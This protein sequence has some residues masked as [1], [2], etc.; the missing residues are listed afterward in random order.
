MRRLLRTHG[1]PLADV[2]AVQVWTSAFA[3]RK[4]LQALQQY[5]VWRFEIDWFAERL[6]VVDAG[7]PVDLDA[8]V[9]GIA[10]I[11]AERDAMIDHAIERA[12][13]VLH[14][15]IEHL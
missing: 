10:K 13:I 6:R 1:D 15:A 9:L 8:V 2:L 3:R 5:F 4:I 7:R 14:P 12:P 11:G